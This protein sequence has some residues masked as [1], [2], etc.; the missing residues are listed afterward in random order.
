MSKKHTNIKNLAAIAGLTLTATSADAALLAV[1][2]NR[3]S[4]SLTESGFLAQDTSGIS[5]TTTAGNI[6]V[7]FT[8]QQGDF[9]R[10]A[11]GGTNNSLYRDFIFDNNGGSPDITITLSGAGIAASSDYIMTFYAYDSGDS[12]RRTGIIGIN[13]TTGPTLGPVVS[14]GTGVPDSLDEYA[15][16]G[17]F[18]SDGVGNLTFGIDGL[19]G[20]NERTVINGFQLDAVAVAVPEPSTTAL[21]GL[22]GLALILRRR[23]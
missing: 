7:T 6:L 13:G 19:P 22:G 23:K 15:V 16:T 20:G 1:D 4:G 9:D 10:G 21:L 8:G 5:H 2:F 17:T 12:S 3:D 18:T 14:Q 11:S